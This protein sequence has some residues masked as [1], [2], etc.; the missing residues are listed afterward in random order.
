MV[1]TKPL[2]QTLKDGISDMRVGVPAMASTSGVASSGTIVSDNR[3]INVNVN[4]SGSG[5]NPDTVA[6][7]IVSAINKQEN[8]RN[9][10]RSS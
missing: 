3:V 2:T 9:F 1:L 7:R 10:G 4:A 6:Q 8:R 5:M